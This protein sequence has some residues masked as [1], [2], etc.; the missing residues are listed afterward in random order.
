MNYAEQVQQMVNEVESIVVMTPSVSSFNKRL[1]EII[2]IHKKAINIYN[3][4]SGSVSRDYVAG[5]IAKIE[6]MCIEFAK[7]HR[8]FSSAV[9]TIPVRKFLQFLFNNNWE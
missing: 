9:S 6:T 5:E 4:I 8:E 7:Q 1:F 2:S 3:L